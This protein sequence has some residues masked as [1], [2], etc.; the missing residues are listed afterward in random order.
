MSS[1]AISIVR[2]KKSIEIF[3]KQL[4]KLGLMD[5]R[6]SKDEWRTIWLEIKLKPAYSKNKETCQQ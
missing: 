6:E 4:N 3:G 1:S 5:N 2:A